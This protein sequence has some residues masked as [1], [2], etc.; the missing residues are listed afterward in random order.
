VESLLFQRPYLKNC[1]SDVLRPET[2][3]DIGNYL[4]ACYLK[5]DVLYKRC[6]NCQKYFVATGRSNVKYCDREVGDTGKTC[7][8]IGFSVIYR[9]DPIEQVFQR[10]YKTQYS[11]VSAGMLSKDMFKEWSK[12]ARAKRNE[13][14]ESKINTE[15][16]QRWLEGKDK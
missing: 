16:F 7:R 11:R 2:P 3:E 9:G 8:Q 4:M 12:S 15:A 13:C 1:F 6:E 5:S 10:A 14:V